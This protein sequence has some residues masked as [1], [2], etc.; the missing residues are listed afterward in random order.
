M[1]GTP[2]S[3]NKK[4]FN[5]SL[6]MT[7]LIYDL[8]YVWWTLTVTLVETETLH[9]QALKSLVFLGHQN[10]CVFALLSSDGAAPSAADE[11]GS[12]WPLSAFTPPVPE[13][14][15]GPLLG[16]PCSP[17]V[18]HRPDQARTEDSWLSNLW[19]PPP[20]GLGGEEAHRTLW[21]CK[22]H[23]RTSVIHLRPS[24]VKVRLGCEIKWQRGL[25]AGAP[26]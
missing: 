19:D 13:D 7:F 15:H 20:L 17:P 14:T 2:Q 11:D 6:T 24:L 5:L 18:T 12:T 25:A 4:E 23:P 10:S 22:F 3:V 26:T 21:S 16:S 1:L 9:F 8:P